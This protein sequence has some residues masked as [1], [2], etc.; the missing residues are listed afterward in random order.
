M[1]SLIGDTGQTA[2]AAVARGVT[3]AADSTAA[4]GATGAAPVVTGGV[5]SATGAAGTA[6]GGSMVLAAAPVIDVESMVSD[7]PAVKGV[8]E[9]NSTV[10]FLEVAEGVTTSIGAGCSTVVGCWPGTRPEPNTLVTSEMIFRKAVS[11]F[12][13]GPSPGASLRCSADLRECCSPGLVLPLWLCPTILPE[14]S[15]SA[16]ATAVPLA[17]RRPAQTAQLPTARCTLDLTTVLTPK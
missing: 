11:A 12:F 2:A 17:S 14:S 16:A 15:G 10:S 7:E 9:V 5:G 6:A 1:T 13:A 8:G 3:G 4:A